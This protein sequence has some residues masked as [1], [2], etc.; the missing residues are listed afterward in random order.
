MLKYLAIALAL[1]IVMEIPANSQNN[2]YGNHISFLS[3]P[4][5]NFSIGGVNT[6]LKFFTGGRVLIE[7]NEVNYTSIWSITKNGFM[8]YTYTS[9]ALESTSV[10]FPVMGLSY[11]TVMVNM[12]FFI[13]TTTY[14]HPLSI[15]R[16]FN[17][18][19]GSP[20]KSGNTNT[21]SI[22]YNI[23]SHRIILGAPP[24]I[25]LSKEDQQSIVVPEIFYF[26]NSPAPANMSFKSDNSNFNS[27]KFQFGNTLKSLYYTFNRTYFENGV[28][29]QA[30][31]EFEHLSESHSLKTGFVFAMNN[32]YTNITYDPYVITPDVTLSNF[33]VTGPLN[34][35]INYLLDN[36]EILIGGFTAGLMIIGAGYISYRKR[37]SL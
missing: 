14:I 29:K 23:T 18:N 17:S 4:G 22:S 30:E 34:G 28:A 25:N 5:I 6:T 3:S 16:T 10:S 36:S 20:I 24:L 9:D 2:D 19:N 7:D 32:S 1:L 13:N 35:A 11:N 12:L 27:F 15:N 26:G 8:N 31:V 37:S 33:N 21:L